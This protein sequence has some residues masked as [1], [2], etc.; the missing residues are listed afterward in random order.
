M[1]DLGRG[2]ADGL[3]AAIGV[4]D[5]MMADARR[6]RRRIGTDW[7]SREYLLQLSDEALRVLEEVRAE[8]AKMRADGEGPG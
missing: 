5:G 1:D 6:R 7:H 3:E 4:V 8:L 2:Y